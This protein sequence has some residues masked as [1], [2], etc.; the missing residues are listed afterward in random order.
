M[1]HNHSSIS[2]S[3]SGIHVCARTPVSFLDGGEII[4]AKFNYH[5]QEN[6]ELTI[7]KNERLVLLDDSCLWWK[8]KRV[9]SDDA[10]YVPRKES[11]SCRLLIELIHPDSDVVVVFR[12]QIVV[13]RDA[14][15]RL[16]ACVYMCR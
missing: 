12:L 3:P 8:V 1:Q 7:V 4:V 16:P 14:H 6:H 11:S 13:N 10:G 5:A 2:K 9:D 15:A